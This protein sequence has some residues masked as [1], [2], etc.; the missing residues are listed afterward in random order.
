MILKPKDIAHIRE[1]SFLK[2]EVGT[3]LDSHEEL[4]DSLKETKWALDV[5]IKRNNG[6]PE[7]LKRQETALA[8][9]DK[10]LKESDAKAS[11]NYRDAVRFNREV[12]TLQQQFD[13]YKENVGP[14]VRFLDRIAGWFRRGNQ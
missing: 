7:I 4:R 12:L 9:Q 8:A 11:R 2:F 6:L 10:L 3:L 13:Q 5:E 14:I 1:H